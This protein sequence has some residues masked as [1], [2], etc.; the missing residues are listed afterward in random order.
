MR[1]CEDRSDDAADFVA[2][3]YSSLRSSLSRQVLPICQDVGGCHWGFEGTRKYLLASYTLRSALQWTLRDHFL[4]FSE[5][6]R[7]EARLSRAVHLITLGCHLWK[8]GGAEEFEGCIVGKASCEEWVD[9]MLLSGEVS[10][11]EVLLADDLYE[12]TC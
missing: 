1:A 10:S 7:S 3:S 6:R 8:G 11:A 5:K 2:V 4:P 12:R 9:E